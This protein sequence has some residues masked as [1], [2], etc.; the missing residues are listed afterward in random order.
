MI[1]KGCARV[2]DAGA[3][4]GT[5]IVDMDWTADEGVTRYQHCEDSGCMCQ[6][7]ALGSWSGRMTTE[8]EESQ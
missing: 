4:P 1:C 5:T 3:P 8:G 6:H 7:K 2:A